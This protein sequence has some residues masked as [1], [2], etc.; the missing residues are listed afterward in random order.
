VS[1]FIRKIRQKIFTEKERKNEIAF[2]SDQTP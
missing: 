2:C 1:Q